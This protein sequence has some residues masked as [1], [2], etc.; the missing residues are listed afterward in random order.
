MPSFAIMRGTN[1]Q[2]GDMMTS[3]NILIC[4]KEMD[5][6]RRLAEYI[7]AQRAYAFRVHYCNS[8]ETAL[9]VSER[10]PVDYLLIDHLFTE[11]ESDQLKAQKWFVLTEHPGETDPRGLTIFMYSS[12]SEILDEMIR[13]CVDDRLL[14][15]SRRAADI[16]LIGFYSP[17]KR[18]GQTSLALE[19]GK[20]LAREDGTL[21]LNLCPYHAQS[22]LNEGS[23]LEDMIYFIRQDAPNLG[24]RLTTMAGHLEG[25]DYLAPFKSSEDLLEVS[26]QEWE[27]LLDVIAKEGS[28]GLVLLDLGDGM[29]GRREILKRCT[30]IYMPVL[31]DMCSQEKTAAF[32]RELHLYDEKELAQ[33]IRKVPMEEDKEKVAGA[34]VRSIISG[35]TDGGRI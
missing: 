10:M 17:V 28:Y 24:L 2:R 22:G 31:D 25:L 35:R 15:G 19:V 5:Y 27:K 21:Y 3:K 1:S 20:R 12:G 29:L 6:A 8:I 16:Q 9:K 7:S 33:R 30:H 23:S 4:V 32:V 26:P 18:V 11:A 14:T 34:L 13:H